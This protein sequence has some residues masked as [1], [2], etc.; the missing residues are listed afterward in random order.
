METNV[1]NIPGGYLT[2]SPNFKILS[3]NQTLLQFIHYD[4][5]QLIGQSIR[6]ILSKSAQA[7]F[8]FAFYPLIIQ[9]K[10]VNE[11]FLELM[12]HTGEEIPV[13]MYATKENGIITCMFVPNK[14]RNE[15]ENQ[16]LEAKRI[17]EERLVEKEKMNADLKKVLLKLEEKQNE[18]IMMSKENDK[19]KIDT[20]SELKLAKKIQETTLTE[21][22]NNKD[23]QIE[24]YY[25]ASNELSGDI[26]GFHQINEDQYG[27]ILLDVMGHGISSS[28]ITMSLVTLFQQLIS[29]GLPPEQIMK[30]LDDKMHSLF[31]NEEEAWHYCT[32]VY[33]FVD[34]K[35]QTIEYINAGHPPAIYLD[36]KGVQRE[37]KTQGPPIGTFK[38][39]QFKNSVFSYTKGAR[40]L[41]YTDGV[42]EPLE[43]DRLS[44]LLQQ[45]ASAPLHVFKEELLKT[46]QDEGNDYEKSDDQCFILIDLK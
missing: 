29:K 37:L 34:I 6:S 30:A 43:Q 19:Y 27:I 35:K 24:S 2:L 40:I 7:F 32:A 15:Y 12:S 13:L 46:L 38:D 17:A 20:Q 18:I 21:A 36:S 28:L 9:N 14:K 31:E 25:R 8:Q 4:S 33:I 42:S 11:M 16:L 5:E 1:N 26:Y 22:I 41:L 45:H 10:R 23:L 3:V 44:L 39:I